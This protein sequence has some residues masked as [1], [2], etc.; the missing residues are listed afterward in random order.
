MKIKD[1]Y[2][3]WNDFPQ[4]EEDKKMG[5]NISEHIGDTF[6]MC[7]THT[8][9]EQWALIAQALRIHGLKITE[10]VF[11]EKQ[12]MCEKC[13]TGMYLDVHDDECGNLWWV[14]PKC[15]HTFD[16]KYGEAVEEYNRRKD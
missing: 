8:P 7:N 2:E 12:E 9:S 14:C 5:D 11:G 4:E 16:A 13:D 1:R 6:I 3:G 15:S 10:Q